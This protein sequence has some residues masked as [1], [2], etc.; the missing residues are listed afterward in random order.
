MA[1]IGLVAGRTPGSA[2]ELAKV[3]SF[4]I[5][6]VFIIGPIAGVYVDRW[7]KRTTLFL[8]DFIRGL[9]ILTIPLL[10][11]TRDSMW[12]IYGIVFLSFCLTRF[13][14]PAKMAIVP[15]I[16]KGTHLLS[17]NSLLTLTGMIAFVL[18][19]ACG[20]FIVEKWGAAGGFLCDAVTFFSSSLL[21]ML[22]SREGKLNVNPKTILNVSREMM[23]DIRKSVLLEIKDGFSYLVNHHDIRFIINM[24]FTLFSAA[25]AIYVV[26]IVFVQEAFGSVTLDLAILAVILGA[27]LFAGSVV[28]GRFGGKI[29]KLKTIFFSLIL[30]GGMLVLFAGLVQNHPTLLLAGVLAFILGVVTGPIF[31]ASNTIIH[32]VSDE[33]MRGKVFSSLEVVI[34]FAFMLAMLVSSFLAEHI[35]R[36]WILIGVGIIFAIVGLVGLLT[37]KKNIHLSESLVG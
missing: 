21:I 30:G 27:G 10:F 13:Y 28:Y 35:E 11:I 34:H 3:L 25:G 23:G 9:L 7:D 26:V 8:C 15:D 36:Y 33:N 18:G 32:Q 31:I 6:P 24:L 20:G 2:F 12:P 1:L 37:Y 29:P 17:A 22:M 4:S 14:V 19:C 16:V 5:I